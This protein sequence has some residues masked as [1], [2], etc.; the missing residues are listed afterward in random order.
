MIKQ[1]RNKSQSTIIKKISQH[2]HGLFLIQGPPG[3]GKTETIANYLSLEYS[4]LQRPN[5]IMVCSQSNAAINHIVH[6][7]S[8]NG[9]IGTTKR[10][11]ILRLGST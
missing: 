4:H 8:D 7:I 10:P 1:S 11:N 6:K 2:D 3:T 5:I 9:L